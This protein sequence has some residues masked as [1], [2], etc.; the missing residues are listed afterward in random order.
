LHT[1]KLLQLFLLVTLSQSERILLKV[2]T[3]LG[4]E[5]AT[6]LDENSLVGE[7]QKS[8]D[9]GHLSL[10]SGTFFV[11]LK[12]QHSFNTIPLQVLQ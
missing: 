9:I 6:I 12:T 1:E 5:I 3:I 2:F 10:V 4:Q 11:Q 8:L 7:Y